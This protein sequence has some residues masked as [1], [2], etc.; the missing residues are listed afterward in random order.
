MSKLLKILGN[1]ILIAV[2][3]TLISVIAL[4]FLVRTPSFQTFLAIK[5]SHFLQDRLNSKVTVG[6]VDIAFFD[7][8]YLD[9]LYVEDLHKDTLFYVKEVY[10]NYKLNDKF[11][12]LDF[13]LDKVKVKDAKFFLKRYK[14][15]EEL[16]LQFFINAFKTGRKS[17]K[18]VNFTLK[19]KELALENA[20][21]IYEDQNKTPL[22]FGVDFSNL[23]I[24]KIDINATDVVV[25]KDNYKADFKHIGF[26]D[27]SGFEM[28]GFEGRAF[29]DLKKGLIVEE[30]T[31]KTGNSTL[32]ANSFVMETTEIADY[33]VF[34]DKV[35]LIGD[36]DTSYVSLLD[37]SYFAP[38]LK[39]MN[40][41][42]KVSGKSKNTVHD[43]A[44][45]D[46][47]LE[48]GKG[49]KV[50]GNFY[51][52]DFRKLSKEYI[53]QSLDYFFILAEDLT[54]LKLPESSPSPYITWPFA[55]NEFKYLEG[56]NLSLK[57]SLNELNTHLNVI[58]SN[59]G[60][61]SFGNDFTVYTDT[62]FNS[63]KII[64]KNGTRDI[65]YIE[66]LDAN[67][68]LKDKNYGTVNAELSLSSLEIDKKG[69]RAKNISGTLFKTELFGYKYDYIVLEKVNYSLIKGRGKPQSEALGNIYLRDENLD[70]SFNGFFSMGNYLEMKADLSIECAM[71]ES[72]HPD[73]KG[74]GELVTNINV[75]AKGKNFNDFVGNILIDSLH[76]QEGDKSF[77]TQNF[78]GFVERNKTKDSISVKSEI[79]DLEV[80]GLIDYTVVSQNI[81]EQ[82]AKVFPAINFAERKPIK[83]DKTYFN[84]D[85][86]FK[87]VNEILDVFMPDIKVA[88]NAKLF[89]KYIGTKN[90]IGVDLLAD[91][92][93]YKNMKFLD[94]SGMQE[95]SNQELIALID[96]QNFDYK[97]STFYKG[98]HFTG[99]ASNGKLDSQLLFDDT[100]NKR[101]N[102]EW[103]TNLQENNAIDVIIHPSYFNF[104]GK[105]WDIKEVANINYSD[106]CFTVSDLKLQHYNQYISAHGFL[107]NS[108]QDKLYLDVM[109][110]DLKEVS[111][112]FFL[113][114]KYHGKANISGY[115]T[116]PLVNLQFNGEAVVEDFKV[117]NTEV[118]VVGFGMNYKSSSDKLMIHGDIFSKNQQTFIFDGYYVTKEEEEAKGSINFDMFFNKTDISVVNEFLSP[119]LF[120]K[121]GAKLNGELKLKG[122]FNEPVLTGKLNVEDGIINL[123]I[124]DADMFFEGEVEVVEDGIYIN[125]MPLKDQEGNTGSV[126]GTLIHDKLKDMF[127]EI[128]VNLESHPTKRMPDDRS[129]PFPVDRFLV[130]NTT[131]DVDSPYYGEAYATGIA[132]VSGHLD[133]LSVVVNAKTRRGTKFV[134]PLYG[135][136]TIDEDGFISF[137]KADDG[138]D[139]EKRI[140]LSGLDLQLNIEA[141]DDAEVKIIFDDKSGD[142]LAA[143]GNGNIRLSV[144][145]FNELA[146]DG[147][148]TVSKGSYNFVLGPYSQVFNI[149]PGGTVQWVGDPY[150][151]I[152]DINA[153]NKT[154]TNLSV[155]MPDV[156]ENKSSNNEEVYYYLTIK[157]NMSNPEISFD[158]DA[159]KASEAGKAIISR[160]RSD[161]DELNKQFFSLVISKSLMPLTGMIS[162]SGSSG[163]F[164][165]LASTQINNILNRMAD[166]YSMNVN[167][168]NDDFTGQFSGEF[169]LSKSFL[170]DRLFISG[171]FGVGTR[172]GDN[173][174]VGGE[175]V[176]NQNTFIGDVRI[177]YLLNEDGT[178]RMNAFNESNNNYLLQNEG[179]GQFTQ[180]IGVSYKEDFN[181]LGDFKLFQFFA[182]LFRKKENKVYLGGSRK[183]KVPIPTI[184]TDSKNSIIEENE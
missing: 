60:T 152:L 43:L 47:A 79:I 3:I 33:R 105:R 128:V 99:L 64:P 133:N 111:D 90:Y 21:F 139:G 55:L 1:I 172:R 156:I 132:T 180:G 75:N 10:V 158:I 58:K 170:D 39:G 59:I 67:K 6:K 98:I 184:D 2:E 164:L 29:F 114:T 37:V 125:Q 131:Y 173:G 86:T 177:E 77:V 134:L 22:D 157:E 28:N 65:V 85:V 48:F 62:T 23:D 57:G 144:D 141:T 106:S 120:K 107:S 14:G 7:K 51:L 84:Y 71:L 81:V 44:L 41:V 138:S 119:K 25:F 122:T 127:F 123:A 169:G 94:I 154:M 96:I 163:A 165:D 13:D 181:N 145:Q 30:T 18:D 49:S 182:N 82:I 175:G 118:G 8:I 52:P 155:V 38:Q 148:Y 116:T 31:I 45:N 179:R 19:T 124:L 91:Y 50:N 5:A 109:D 183:N 104:K 17:E 87:D 103:F 146:M 70:L 53:N 68:I 89:G 63:F 76:Y 151:A 73:L 159:P 88:N 176:P 34:V 130:M 72:L 166:G 112:L 136:T 27:H 137:K 143:R 46:I 160:I 83:E 174:N 15:E 80:N 102:L 140:D 4:F 121:L 35:K 20:H 61:V 149:A 32:V 135:P 16:N 95:V 147:T 97:D 171:S 26:V 66:N 150:D 110:L 54:K 9:E 92:I 11:L 69:V 12:K 74:R 167:L 168:E 178:F 117:N 42:V 161:R 36:L 162:A 142:E 56:S 78:H 101:S 113:E 93:T 129:K 108:I 24:N 153:Y 115:A 40:D 126:T 100:E